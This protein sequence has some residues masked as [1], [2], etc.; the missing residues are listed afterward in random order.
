[1][2]SIELAKKLKDAGL[3]WEP[4]LGDLFYWDDYDHWERDVLK[5]HDIQEATSGISECT[6]D[7][8]FAP[9]LEQ[10]LNAIDKCGY[11]WK[12]RTFLT[13]NSPPAP[14]LPGYLI[15]AWEGEYPDIRCTVLGTGEAKLAE[16]VARA[17]LIILN[18][19][20]GNAE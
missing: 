7:W 15:E 17:L 18:R 19:E 14:R 9:R 2:L 4:A 16:V 6:A 1:M 8:I 3:P 10:L 20:G 5:E 12:L 11:M 13:G